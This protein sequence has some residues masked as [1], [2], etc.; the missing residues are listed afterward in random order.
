MK[1]NNKKPHFHVTAGL[2]W[3]DGR[4]LI[5]KRPEGSHLAGFWEFPGGK[6]E[7]DETLKRCLRREIKEELGLDIRAN[8]LLLTVQ[9][10]YETKLI[11]LHIFDC[12]SLKGTPQALERQDMKWVDPNDLQQYT[13][14]PPDQKI[15]EFITLHGKR[16]P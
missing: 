12:T 11:T 6:Q 13:F 3:Q 4:L 16:L 10:E 7:S 8:E 1:Q 14:P 15:I 2:I 9:H 5:T